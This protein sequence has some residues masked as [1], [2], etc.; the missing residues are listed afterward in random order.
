VEG[1]S[2]KK[3]LLIGAGLIIAVIGIAV[4]YIVSSLDS[5]VVAGVEKFGSEITQTR[6]RLKEAKITLT[7]GQGTLRGLSVGNPEGFKTD[8][9][10]QLG[11][12]SVEI[13]TGT[14]T[15]NPVVIKKIVID[16]PEITYEMG[17]KG[18]NI[19]AI[20]RNVDTYMAKWGITPGKLGKQTPAKGDEGEARK[21]IIQN[22][23][24]RNG[25]VNISASFLGGK[26]LGAPLPDIHLKD[27]GKAKGGASPGE[28]AGEIIS[29][30]RQSTAKGIAPLGL[31]K[32]AGAVTEG[33]KGSAEL[34]EKGAKGSV[35]ILEKGA[36]GALGTVEE[37]VKGTGDALKKLFGK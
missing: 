8:T 28:I 5:L 14:I 26:K 19:D 1:F 27:I 35:E 21:L 24:V 37:S 22:L 29:S 32:L 2:M 12:I 23:Y 20:Q 36:K 31:D 18:S 25:K 34:L 33:L 15:Q 9:S 16:S 3:W 30:I 10:I 4:F 17:E 11:E 7:S 13:D 6:V